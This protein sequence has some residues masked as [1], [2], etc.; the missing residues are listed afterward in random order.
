MFKES[1]ISIILFVVIYQIYMAYFCNNDDN[2]I[3]RAINTQ[4]Q[5]INNIPQKK[6]MQYETPQN[7]EHPVL[8]KPDK[9]IQ[10]GYLFIIKNP[11]PWNAI[12]FNPNKEN[13]YLFIIRLN[14][15]NS[16][17]QSYLT[18]ISKW[19][20]IIQG[21]QLNL[22]NNELVIPSEDDNTALG[23]VNIIINNLKGDISLKNIIDN[24]LISISIAKIRTYPSIRTKIIEQIMEN[25]N[26]ESHYP[27]NTEEHLE[28][29]EDLAQ[30]INTTEEHNNK[31]NDNRP[32]D[33]PNNNKPNDN[34]PFAYEGNEFSYI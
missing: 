30:L 21:I 34:N 19:S 27:N 20:E 28:Y 13:K 26:G 6:P 18:K 15:K 2:N 10:E 9:I 23:I 16:E 22:D 11:Q 3:K 14:I 8:G 7:F 1:L 17:K 33:N 4:F 32:N 25:I 29:E 12:V 24:N 31:P 5:K